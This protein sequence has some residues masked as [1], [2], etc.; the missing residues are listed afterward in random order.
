VSDGLVVEVELCAGGVAHRD[1]ESLPG[2]EE[3][4]GQSGEV[5]VLLDEELA[6]GAVAAFGAG[7]ACRDGFGA[8]R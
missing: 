3:V 8:V 7:T 4:V 2:G 1:G 5:G 6:H